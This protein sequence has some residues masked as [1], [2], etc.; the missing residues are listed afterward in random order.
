MALLAVTTF[1]SAQVK[2]SAEAKAMIDKAVAATQN[3][4]KAAKAGTWIN[5]GKAYMAAYDAPIGEVWT[6]ASKQELTLTMGELT[7]D[8]RQIILDGC[9]INYRKNMTQQ[10]KRKWRRPKGIWIL[11]WTSFLSWKAF[12][13][14]Q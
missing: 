10:E 3:E 7:A 13:A 2:T 14:G 8:E 12:P 5:L 9:L 11:Y 6:G 1:A 4:K